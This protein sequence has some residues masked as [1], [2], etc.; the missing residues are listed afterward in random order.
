MTLN[1]PRKVRAVIYIFTALGMPVM[2]YL[3]A[4][5]I[6]GPL[7]MALWG[8]EVTAVMAMAGLNVSNK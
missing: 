3:L 1:P 2:T 6:I 8:A 5:E 4:K 7:E